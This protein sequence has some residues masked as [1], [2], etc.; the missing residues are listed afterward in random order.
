MIRYWLPVCV[1][2]V[3]AVY[4]LFAVP[5]SLWPGLIAGAFAS[6]VCVGAAAIYT[7]RKPLSMKARIIGGLVFA[8]VA[9]SLIIGW[10]GFY[11]TTH[12]QRSQLLTIQKIIADGQNR[13]YLNDIN[14]KV[15]KEFHG[16]KRTKK[17]SLGNIF[18]Q[19]Y[20]GVK[21][22]D[23]VYKSFSNSDSLKIYVTTLSD[24]RLELVAQPAYVKGKDPMFKNINGRLGRKQARSILT[25]RGMIYEQQN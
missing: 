4:F 6:G 19:L 3:T 14:M 8:A 13:A 5:D 12:W 23:N 1:V 25:E 22:G 7:F 18:R 16:Q 21:I 24:T 10:R 11:L 9:F 20:P 15:L 17:E 2:I